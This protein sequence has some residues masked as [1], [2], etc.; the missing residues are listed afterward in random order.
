MRP[1][2]PWPC[3]TAPYTQCRG[4][5]ASPCMGTRR[6]WGAS[7][8]VVLCCCCLQEMRRPGPTGPPPPSSAALPQPQPA[9]APPGVRLVAPPMPGPGP[10]SQPEMQLA[11]MQQQ[12]Q[13]PPLVL[14]PVQ[15]STLPLP[16]PAPAGVP[17]VPVLV[18]QPVASS[19]VPAPQ[20]SPASGANA[21]TPSNNNGN[22]HFYSGRLSDEPL[23]GEVSC[24][25]GRPAGRPAGR[26]FALRS[27]QARACCTHGQHTVVW[28]MLLLL[29]VD[30]RSWR[31]RRLVQQFHPSSAACDARRPWPDT[32]DTHIHSA[33]QPAT[34][35]PALLRSNEP[36]LATPLCACARTPAVGRP[37][38]QTVAVFAGTRAVNGTYM[39]REGTFYP[40][41]YVTG[42]STAIVCNCAECG[43]RARFAPSGFERHCGS[44][45]HNPKRTIKVG[46]PSQA[47]REWPPGR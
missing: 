8:M 16:P 19:P 30:R 10:A 14:S 12:Q 44:A 17:P 21:G 36:P 35:A 3:C 22:S 25:Y 26:R 43:G 34:P 31:G 45:A 6:V 4:P 20:P 24:V 38:P 2:G 11:S 47:R 15:A 42:V 29:C 7:N 33:A 37:P 41:P 18:L 1:T 40:E 9:P 39:A 32:H 5:V 28:H 13:Q 46:H 27:T 23:Y